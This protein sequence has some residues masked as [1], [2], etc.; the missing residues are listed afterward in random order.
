MSEPAPPLRLFPFR[1]KLT[2]LVSGLI[3]LVLLAI[4]VVMQRGVEAEFRA[5]VVHQLAQADRAVAE[6]MEER[7]QHLFRS[8]VAAAGERLVLEVLTDAGLSRLTRDDIVADEVLPDLVEV[9]LLA[10]FDAD[11]GLLAQ[12]SRLGD[13]AGGLTRAVAQAAWSRICCRGATPPA[14]C[15]SPEASRRRWGCPSSSARRSPAASCWAASSLS[16][17]WCA[18]RSRRA[19]TSRS[20]GRATRRSVA[21]PNARRARWVREPRPAIDAAMAR[22]GRTG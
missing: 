2:L 7:Y 10:I 4:L 20:S 12:G 13:A 3:V 19:P 1:Y 11:G 9:D 18:S 17:T 6:E 15:G 21:A 22:P 16:S 14:S 8:A 5:L